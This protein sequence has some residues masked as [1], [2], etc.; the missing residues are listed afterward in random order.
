MKILLALPTYK[1]NPRLYLPK[2]I[3]EGKGSYPP[4]GVLYLASMLKKHGYTDIAVFDGQLYK[5]TED[6]FREKISRL[7]PQVVGISAFTPTLH[8]AYR[9][10]R[11]AKS[12]NR[13]IHVVFGGPHCSIY[14]REVISMDF[15]DA[16]VAGEGEESFTRVVSAIDSGNW[17]GEMDGVLYKKNGEIAGN[18]N[19][20]IIRNLDALPFPDRSLV[21][22]DRYYIVVDKPGTATSLLTSRG[23]PFGCT[24]CKPARRV[25]TQRSP[26]SIAVEMEECSGM[27]FRMINLVDDTFNVDKT[28]VL[29]ICRE[30]VRRKIGVSWSFMGR[31]E[32][33]DKEMAEALRE[34]GCSRI[35]FGIEA[36]TD[37]VLGMM[38]KGFAVDEA[39]KAIE[40]SKKYGFITVAFFIL[41]FPGETRAEIMDTINFA[42]KT[43]PDYAQFL[44]L[45]LQPG[46]KLYNDAL[47]DGKTEDIF[48]NF[49]LDPAMEYQDIYLD[50]SL[51]RE[52]TAKLVRSAFQRFYLRK[53]YIVKILR[54]TRS[55]TEF[56]R[57]L[58]ALYLMMMYQ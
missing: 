31:V 12:F 34:A 54:L 4:L 22:K 37:R 40:I 39:R 23:C 27:G 32:T 42:I 13:N 29:E 26:S 1:N 8:R 51:S 46:T 55:P 21:P 2:L 38:Q 48:K 45:S 56:L 58:R 9:L 57:K 11:I 44:P 14:P 30:I 49:T 10:A 52:E 16:V 50:G 6:A 28:K 41:G 33:F 19:Y 3:T 36:G 43:E 25:F 18:T 35:Q 5:N 53:S 17:T 47:R 15:I 24:F 20:K 7:N